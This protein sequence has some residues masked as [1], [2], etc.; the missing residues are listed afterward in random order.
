MKCYGNT[1]L[2]AFH[3][4]QPLTAIMSEYQE[5]EVEK[6]ITEQIDP[7]VEEEKAFEEEQ[8]E[9]LREKEEEEEGTEEEEE[10]SE[11]D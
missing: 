8:A 4:P 2:S 7:T 11:E 6:E 10:E 5:N 1:Y 3:I 9:K